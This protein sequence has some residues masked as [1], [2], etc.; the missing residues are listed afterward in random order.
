MRANCS[1]PEAAA[2][3]S[4][5]IPAGARRGNPARHNDRLAANLIM[6]KGHGLYGV[7]DPFVQQVWREKETLE[8]GN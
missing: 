4:K 2:D 8:S 3:H 5:A 7:T 1:P 6:R